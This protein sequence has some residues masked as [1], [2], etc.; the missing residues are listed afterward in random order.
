MAQGFER[1]FGVFGKFVEKEHTVVRQ[2]H[3]AGL[4]MRAAPDECHVRDGVVGRAEGACG[5]EGVA[6]PEF[7]RHRM[8]L[9]G[10]QTFRQT[11]GR[12]N[13]GEAFG[14]H[15]LAA[16]RTPH[17]Q[18]VVPAGR[19]HFE[20]AF[21]ER[22]AFHLAEIVGERLLCGVKFRAGVDHGGQEGRPALEVA[23]ELREVAHG[24]HLHA[25]H[26]RGLSGILFG[27]EECGVAHAAGED[28]G[29]ENAAHRSEIAVEPQ[30]AEKDAPLNRGA[31]RVNAFVRKQ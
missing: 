15:A 8:N 26:H 11:E 3:L 4:K 1:I 23:D 12:Q 29:G 5:N 20:G 22:L 27:H 18:D 6:A 2:T 9:R 13:R 21:Y 28:G 31:D 7:S 10:L 24:E 16:A 17:E 19:R 14:H 25:V 30:F